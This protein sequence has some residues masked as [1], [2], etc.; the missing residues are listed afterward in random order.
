MNYSSLM[1][2]KQIKIEK[3]DVQKVLSSYQGSSYFQK[4]LDQSTEQDISPTVIKYVYFNRLFGAGVAYLSSRLALQT[5]LFNDPNE[6][7]KLWSDRSMEVAA[8]VFAAAIDEFGDRGLPSHPTHRT[9][10]QQ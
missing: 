3:V 6:T 1:S 2:N 5:S 10:A 8:C 4:T 7:S 9:M